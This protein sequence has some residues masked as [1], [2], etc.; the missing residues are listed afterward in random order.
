M[1]DDVESIKKSIKLYMGVFI[2]LLV[3]TVVTVAVAYIPFSMTGHVIVAL[4][5]ASIKAGLVAAF[6]MHLSHEKKLIYQTLIFT[7]IFFL[8]LIFLSLLAKYDP[9]TL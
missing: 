7:F 1:A 2:A 5:I 8:G 9:I 4:F 3:L 6:F